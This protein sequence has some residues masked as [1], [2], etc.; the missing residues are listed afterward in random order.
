MEIFDEH[1]VDY[2]TNVLVHKR[3]TK[4]PEYF[5]VSN[6]REGLIDCFN[7]IYVV[8]DESSN[9]LLKSFGIGLRVV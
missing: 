8:S 4:N 3:F 1:T 9:N 5:K 2:S 6:L 7:A